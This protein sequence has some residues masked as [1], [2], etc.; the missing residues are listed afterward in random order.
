MTKKH[1]NTLPSD[2]SALPEWL[3]WI[4]SEWSEADLFCGHGSQNLSEEA[5]YLL[6]S[7]FDWP[8]KPLEAI[9][10]DKPQAYEVQRLVKLRLETK[11][12]LAYLLNKAWFCGMPFFVDERVLVPRSPI[13]E[14]IQHGFSPWCQSHEI[15]RV[16]DLCTGSGCI[17]IA[18]AEAFPEADVVASD[19]SP[20][21]L[22]VAHTNRASFNLDERVTLV[23]SDLFNEVTGTFDLIVSNPPYV[24]ENEWKELP[25]E[26]FHEPKL[27][28]VSQDDGLEIPLK[29][30]RQA[31]EF[32]NP[33][34][35]LVLEVGHSY[36]QL[37]ASCPQV[38]FVW[39]EFESDA[40]GVCVFTREELVKY[41]SS[42]KLVC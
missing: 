11:K 30:L 5:Y 37:E 33:E 32:L 7:L 3:A 36:P 6:Y 2:K 23:E 25:S 34:G 28:L 1:K 14:L 12:P 19:I 8:D 10:L 17:A 31:P 13:A 22:E 27:G 9:Y 16:L 20:D 18:C 4:E 38:P 42:F 29:I 41:Q 21:A 26:Y 39:V 35:V 40:Q 24:P 15:H